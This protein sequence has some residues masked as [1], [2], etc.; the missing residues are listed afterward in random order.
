[1]TQSLF[2]TLGVK[3]RPGRALNDIVDGTPELTIAVVPS[4]VG[5]GIGSQLLRHLLDAADSVY[6]A[7]YL[8]VRVT[9]PAKRFEL[10]TPGISEAAKDRFYAQ[11]FVDLIQ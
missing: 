2:F 1:L 10:S 4:G 11:N 9:N 3:S 5:Q 6:P 8:S 7:V